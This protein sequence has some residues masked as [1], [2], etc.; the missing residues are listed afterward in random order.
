MH[1]QFAISL[2]EKTNDQL[3]SH[4]IRENGDEDL[5]FALWIP[6]EG[7]IRKTVLIHTLIAPGS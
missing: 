4:L 5:I 7:S 2:S 1:K 3:L 6:S